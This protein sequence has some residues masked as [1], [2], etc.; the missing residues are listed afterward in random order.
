MRFRQI[1]LDF[2]T[3]PEIPDIGSAFDPDIFARTLKQARVNSINLFAKCHHG[4]SYHPTDVGRMH[5]NLDFDLFGAQLDAVK[6]EGI[7]ATAYISAAWDDLAAN[8]R[9][10]LSVVLPED[11]GAFKEDEVAGHWR[12]M[13]FSSAYQDYLLAQVEEVI[14]RYP[15][16]DG[17]WM[18]ICI[19]LPSVS[20]AAKAGMARRGLDWRKATDR[21]VFSEQIILEAM[22]RVADLAKAHNLTVFFNSGHLRR[23]RDEVHLSQL[24]QFELESLPTGNWGYDHFPVS[25]RYFDRLK[26]DV[27]GMTGKFHH[28]WGEM[29]GYKLPDALKYECAMMISQGAG[30]S[31]GDHLHPSGR[32]D[33]STYKS[34]G[35]A[36]EWV[37]AREEWCTGSVNEAEIALISC[38]AVEKPLFS[39]RPDVNAVADD[40]AAR[41][42]LEGKF[43]FDILP[44]DAD[45]SGYR[46]VILPD[47]VPVDDAFE[48]CLKAYIEGGG[49]LLI[50][51]RSGLDG[52][53]SRFLCGADWHGTS[54]FEGGDYALPSPHLRADFVDEPLFMYGPCEQ[55]EPAPG[56]SLG[57]IFEPFF[58]RSNELYSGHQNTPN[59]TEAS[60]HAFGVTQGGVTR[61]AHALF[62]TYHKV[63]SV[64]LQ[65]IAFKVIDFALN[66]PRMIRSNLPVAARA[67]LR[68]QPEAGRSILHLVYGTPTLRGKIRSDLVQV[69]QDLV[70]LHDTEIDLDPGRKAKMVRL[71]PE[72]EP[73]DFEQT[74]N[75]IKFRVD[76]FVGHQMIEIVWE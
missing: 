7:A 48:T 67:S 1:H 36:Y 27:I 39:G 57:E 35:H 16:I 62:S 23:G 65:Q 44:P 70:P 55:L 50:T 3:A 46:L 40:G 72:N 34:I 41:I 13:D 64:A 8:N 53:N 17:L 52:E 66:Q 68:S 5:P 56:T 37:E 2:H 32:I 42:L 74:G 33:P 22:G 63:G 60:V 30:I 54:P 76:R 58:D 25:A 45:L 6:R 19:Q 11:Q 49:R 51:G 73:L 47:A 71:V 75:R 14:A 20:E 9:D 12:F 28:V 15:Q 61:I 21:Y 4:V 24:T 10:W 38:E 18:D 29:G 26:H 59:K 69:I 31:I 43:T